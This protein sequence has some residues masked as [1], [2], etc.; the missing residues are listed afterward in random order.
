VLLR[1][2]GFT[3]GEITD[4]IKGVDLKSKLDVLLPL[5]DVR[6]SL[7]VR[8]LRAA[9]QSIRNSIVHFKATPSISTNEGDSYGDHEQLMQKAEDF[10]RSHPIKNIRSD[11]A[12]FVDICASQCPEIQA[13]YR[14]LERFM[15]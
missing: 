3:N 6:P 9:S 1:V 7:N 10:F 11:L 4:A 14:L 2:R 13:A 15:N 12:S 5:L 8:Q